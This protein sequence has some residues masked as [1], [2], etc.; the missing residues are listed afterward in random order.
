MTYPLGSK[1][2]IVS[3][4]SNIHIFTTEK[5]AKLNIELQDVLLKEELISAYF[6]YSIRT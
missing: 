2:T 4:R 3:H 1:N 6:G 5:I